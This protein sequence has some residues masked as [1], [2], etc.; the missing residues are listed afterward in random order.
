M[1]RRRMMTCAIGLALLVC[2]DS[3]LATNLPPYNPNWKPTRD[4]TR[5][6]ANPTST[7]RSKNDFFGK[8]FGLKMVR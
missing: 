5:F 4:L 6:F 7:V 1:T 8:Y 3:A 2:V